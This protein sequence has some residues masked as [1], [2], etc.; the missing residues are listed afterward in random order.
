MPS[1]KLRP[2]Q[3]STP[4]LLC[5]PYVCKGL[6]N[7]KDKVKTD[8]LTDIANPGGIIHHYTI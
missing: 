4:G 1:Q 6:K 3:K 5:K 7:S 2:V 8:G